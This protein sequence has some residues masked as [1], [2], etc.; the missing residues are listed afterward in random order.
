MRGLR[1]WRTGAILHGATGED[2]LCLSVA[3]L[4][5][6]GQT[7]PRHL[8]YPDTIVSTGRAVAVR[9]CPAP[10]VTRMSGNQ[11]SNWASSPG[12]YAVREAGSG[13]R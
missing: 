7:A 13:G 5:R 3:Q 4:A 9:C 11:K 12:S 8:E 1:L 10:T 2:R 6:G